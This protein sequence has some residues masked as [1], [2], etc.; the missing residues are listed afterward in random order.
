MKGHFYDFLSWFGV[1]CSSFVSI[2]AGTSKRSKCNSIGLPCPSVTESN[3]MLERTFGGRAGLESIE[4]IE[5]E[6]I[7][8]LPYPYSFL[9]LSS[10]FL[11]SV[12]FCRPNRTVCLLMLVSICG[13]TWVLEQPG[14]S[15]L[16]YYPAWLHFLHRYYQMYGMETVGVSAQAFKF[17][18]LSE[19]TRLFLLIFL[20]S[21]SDMVDESLRGA[22]PE[23][24]VGLEQQSSNSS[25]R[26]WVEKDEETGRNMC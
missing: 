16:E 22:K 24:P 4:Y 8:I 10:R 25:S 23:T 7:L 2:N 3:M 1:K 11:S 21:Q 12:W 17:Q 19:T 5:I 9:I 18:P 26:C 15:V 6:T 20:G 14:S 13:G